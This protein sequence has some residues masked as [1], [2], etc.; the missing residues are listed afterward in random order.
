M[1]EQEHTPSG[2]LHP[3]VDPLRWEAAV[4][5]I[6]AAAAPELERRARLASPVIVLSRWRRPVL[7]AAATV[8]LLASAAILSRGRAGELGPG[9]PGGEDVGSAV[10]AALVPGAVANWVMGGEAGSVA[11]LVQALEEEQ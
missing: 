4:S 11:E 2:S 7:S 8:A 9:A 5:G 3:A 10:A 1:S 6:M